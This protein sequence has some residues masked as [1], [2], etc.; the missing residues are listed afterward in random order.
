MKPIIEVNNIWKQY[1]IGGEKQ[2][3]LSLREQI[4]N[5][6]SFKNKKKTF[7]ALE[8]IAFE[9]FQ[10]DCIGIVGRNGAGKSTLLKILS[11]IT[12]PTKGNIKLK[13]RV[14]SLLEVGTGFH[15]ELTGRENIY[16]NGAI[17]GLRKQEINRK[18]DEI[19]DFS[20]VERFLDTA[21]KHYSSGMKLR[22]AFSVAAYLEPE[23]LLI[24]EVLAVGDTEFQRKCIGRMN[25]V[26]QEGRTVIFVSHDLEAVRKL[27]RRGIIL[28]NGRVKEEGEIS[29]IVDKYLINFAKDT[30]KSLAKINNQQILDEFKIEHFSINW[31][32]R[33]MELNLNIEGGD[34]KN[35]KSIVYNI[36][37]IGG[38][39]ISLLDLRQ[40]FFKHTSTNTSRSI[41]IKTK[42]DFKNYVEGMYF[43]SLW[44]EHQNGNWYTSDNIGFELVNNQFENIKYPSKWRGYFEIASTNEV[45]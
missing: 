39:R 44:I 42:A 10:G 25:E 13:G 33:M 19:V 5:A 4:T 34:L 31:E 45:S 17:L 22:L 41:K 36:Y 35:I 24:D 21:L 3:Y 12:P 9:V 32:H 6:F 26:T 16:L 20:G 2:K 7:W 27:C 40:D 1:N 15:P 38:Q 18:F 30:N 37:S 43:I 29:E 11:R 8:D 14:A 28:D 23:I